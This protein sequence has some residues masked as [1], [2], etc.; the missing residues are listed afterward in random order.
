MHERAHVRARVPALA[1]PGASGAERRAGSRSRNLKLRAAPLGGEGDALDGADGPEVLREIGVEDVGIG[2][3]E[4]ASV[5][6]MGAPGIPDDED[7]ALVV[8]AARLH[9]MAA[10]GGVAA[11]PRHGHLAG[12]HGP[13]AL[14]G[15]V[16]HEA[17][18]DGVAAGD[19]GLH[20]LE[21]LVHAG[22][23]QDLV[24]LGLYVGLLVRAVPEAALVVRPHALGADAVL[25]HA[26]D[27][28]ADVG[29]GIL[30]HAA[31]HVALAPVDEQPRRHP[32]LEALPELLVLEGGGE[33]VRG[34]TAE[35]P[36]VVDVKACCLRKSTDGGKLALTAGLKQ[37]NL[38]RGS[39][40]S[41]F[42]PHARR[43]A[44][45]GMA[46]SCAPFAALQQQ[47]PMAAGGGAAAEDRRIGAVA[48]GDGC[49]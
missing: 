29:A 18:D 45:P 49:A 37:R 23:L 30:A 12:Q 28:V 46:S 11:A 17:E 24:L 16:H 14:E 20:V 33:R 8:V 32:G 15:A 34:A 40:G 44:E 9:G 3:V 7:L 35:A 10:H 41:F 1:L 2:H 13:A 5:S 19:A 39:W 21:G 36:L 38:S 26:L 4:M 27:A 22:V 25:H 6:P 47:R 42:Q 48:R 43:G 31:F